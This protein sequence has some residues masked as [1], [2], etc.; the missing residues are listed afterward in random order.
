MDLLPSDHEGGVS[1]SDGLCSKLDFT[2]SRLANLCQYYVIIDQDENS[3][4]VQRKFCV[5]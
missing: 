1:R 5:K 2:N 3:E 4:E